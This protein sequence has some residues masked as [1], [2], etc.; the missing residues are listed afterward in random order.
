[1]HEL[2]TIKFL[3]KCLEILTISYHL[4]SNQVLNRKAVFLILF[5]ITSNFGAEDER[6]YFQL[7]LE[8]ENVLNMFLKLC[9]ILFH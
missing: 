6:S 4:A 3:I 1:M 2:Y 8:P 5:F 9:A 7:R